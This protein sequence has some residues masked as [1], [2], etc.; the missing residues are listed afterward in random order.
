M[1]TAPNGKSY[2][3]QTNNLHRRNIVHK[4]TNGC[5]AFSSAI[6]KYGWDNFTHTILADGLSLDE[7]NR[8]EAEFIAKHNTIS[9]YGYNL[10]TGGESPAF[11][12]ETRKKLSEAGKKRR[13]SDSHRFH[14]S[15]L[16]KAL[17]PERMELLQQGARIA[18]EKNKGKPHHNTGRKHTEETRRRVSEAT[19]AALASDEVRAKISN[20]LIGKKRSKETREKQSEAAKLRWRRSREAKKEAA[21]GDL[22]SPSQTCYAEAEPLN[23]TAK[24]VTGM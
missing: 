24:I 13:L 6:K 10:R 2:I 7:A 9:P 5:R 11:S 16:G 23:G 22:F 20:A 1:H 18:R 14:L 17:S 21:Q 19:K 3:G 8:L 4:N 15:E 12:E